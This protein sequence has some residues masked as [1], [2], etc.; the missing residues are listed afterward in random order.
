MHASAIIL[1]VDAQLVK[2]LLALNREFY[3]RFA[4]E[5]SETRSSSRVNLTPIR[6]YLRD[7]VRVLEVGCGNGRLAERFDREG[8]R[9][10][11]VGVDITSKLVE[12]A[13]S[14]QTHLRNITADF[15]EV[16]VTAPGWS[17][18]LHASAPFDLGLAM[19]VLHHI[20]SFE[21]RRALLRDIHARLRAGGVLLLSN[22]QFTENERLRRKIVPWQTLGIDEHELE[23]GDALLDWRRGGTGYRYVHLL[24]EGEVQS[25]AGESGYQVLEQFYGD[26]NLN[27]YSALLRAG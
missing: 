1:P 3:A 4:E 13:R 24:T 10:D 8:Y 2:R 25:L 27:L 7:G 11:Y 17:V 22:W 16:D 9:L 15:R 6:P 20:P 18:S 23:P 19:A 21:L 5:F 12:T 26:A 14:R